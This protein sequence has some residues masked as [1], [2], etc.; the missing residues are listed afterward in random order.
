MSTIG[1][2]HILVTIVSD[3]VLQCIANLFVN[4]FTNLHSKKKAASIKFETAFLA[5]IDTD[6]IEPSKYFVFRWHIDI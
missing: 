1:R 5:S 2:S 6:L 3:P 4:T